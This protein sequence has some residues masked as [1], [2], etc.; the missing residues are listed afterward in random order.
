MIRPPPSPCTARKAINS[1]MLPDA[2][3]SADPTMKIATPTRISG[4]RP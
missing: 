1:I 3:A 2:P 4:L